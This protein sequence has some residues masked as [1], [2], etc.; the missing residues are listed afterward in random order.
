MR[1]TTRSLYRQAIALL[2]SW[3]LVFA[4]LP[5]APGGTAQAFMPSNALAM[6]SAFGSLS[7]ESMTSDVIEA[8]DNE[9]FGLSEGDLTDNMKAARQEIIEANQDTDHSEYTLSAAH[10]DA[11]NFSGS[12]ARLIEYK[13]KVKELLTA[14]QPDVTG[15]RLYLGHALHTLQDFYSHS[16]WVEQGNT[17]PWGRLGVPGSPLANPSATLPTCTVCARDTCADCYNPATGLT[18]LITNSLTSGYFGGEERTM[19]GDFKCSHGGAGDPGSLGRWGAGINKDTNNCFLSPHN[20]LHG[21]AAQF[22]SQATDVYLSSIQDMVGEKKMKLLL[23]GG[24]TLAMAID[25]TGSMGSIIDSVKEEAINIINERLGTPDEPFNYVLVPFGDPEVGRPWSRM[26]RKSS[27][28]RLMHSK[29]M[30]VVIAR[31]W[32]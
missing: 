32:R 4:A 26:R 23:G 17:G 3:L 19:P 25:T 16:N 5:L 30:A 18:N 22:A 8:Y 11:E 9:L 15:A 20:D 1:L 7:H 27:S 12:Q 2:A 6:L 28:T 13:L 29:L 31:S 14:E 10:F 24:S 21:N